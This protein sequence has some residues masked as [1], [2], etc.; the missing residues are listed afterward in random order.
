M[1][2]PGSIPAGGLIMRVGVVITTYEWPR[3]L[4]LVLEGYA[5]Q[6]RPA[7][8]VVVADDGSGAATRELVRRMARET[9]LPLVH[10]WHEDRGFQKTEILNRAIRAT[11]CDYLVFTDGDCIP[12][13]D[14]VATHVELARPGAFLSG[15]Y[16]RLSE[17]TTSG[18]TREDVRSGR[19]FDPSWLEGHGT[20]LGRHHLRLLDPGMAPRL[21]DAI[22]TTRASWNGMGSSTWTAALKEV[23]GF[24]LDFVY[25][26]L[27]R[28]LGDRLENHGL[29][30]VQV[31]HRAAVLHLHHGRPYKD[32]ETIRK[33]RAK[34]AETRREGRTRALRGLGQLDNSIDH[35]VWRAGDDPPE[36]DAGRAEPTTHAGDG[37]GRPEPTTEPKDGAGRAEPTTQAG[38]GAE[39]GS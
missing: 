39:V 30:G 25:G 23:N 21:L 10:V 27:D 6:D 13:R 5:A 31:R 1:A 32:V 14:F 8:E 9:G 12:R 26:G 15:G 3:A 19:A 24:D 34:R 37:A 7:D 4:E 33:Q 16:V 28:E 36:D 22:T 17:E 29:K 11:D 38:D 20:A 35:W 2:Q 18:L